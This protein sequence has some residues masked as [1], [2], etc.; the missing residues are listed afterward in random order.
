MHQPSPPPPPSNLCTVPKRVASADYQTEFEIFFSDFTRI[1][2][3]VSLGC[4]IQESTVAHNCPIKNK[5]PTSKS[6]L[7]HQTQIRHN[8]SKIVTSKTNSPHRSQTYHIKH[9][10]ATTKAKSSLQKQIHH[11][12]NE[13]VP[14]KTNFSQQKQIPHIK[15]KNTD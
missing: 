1:V 9:K 13:L 3:F 2:E 11:I 6:N 8:K 10:F 12:K 7:L 4:P 15:I 5:F 14:S